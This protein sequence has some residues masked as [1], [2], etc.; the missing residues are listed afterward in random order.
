VNDIGDSHVD[1]DR[2]INRSLQE[3]I[4]K[5]M[6]RQNSRKPEV[7]ASCR[8]SLQLTLKC[9]ANRMTDKVMEQFH[10][11]RLAKQQCRCHMEVSL[12][13]AATEVLGSNADQRKSSL[14]STFIILLKSILERGYIT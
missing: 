13:P 11:E 10:I 12:T 5:Q 1:K 8:T 2:H 14:N 3:M 6:N 9:M 7:R 4:T